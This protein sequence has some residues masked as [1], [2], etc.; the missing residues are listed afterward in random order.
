MGRPPALIALGH[1]ELSYRHLGGS[2]SV[3]PTLRGDFFLSRDK[4]SHIVHVPNPIRNTSGHRRGYAKGF[5]NTTEVVMHV[6]ERDRKRV[7][8][9]LL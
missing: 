5:V 1:Y 8:F 3:W 2:L 4:R 7:V 9:E 6:M